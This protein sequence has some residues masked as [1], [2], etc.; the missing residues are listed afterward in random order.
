MLNLLYCIKLFCSRLL[1]PVVYTVWNLSFCAT[2]KCALHGRASAINDSSSCDRHKVSSTRCIIIFVLWFLSCDLS[3][4]V[5][6]HSLFGSRPIK[7]AMLYFTCLHVLLFA[8]WW[9]DK[10]PW[11]IRPFLLLNLLW[12]MLS[13]GLLVTIKVFIF[14]IVF[15]AMDLPNNGLSGNG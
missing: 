4:I 6:D 5:C 1:H 13:A 12:P 8:C 3:S 10:L 11:N 15:I 9:W 7:L 2:L 14:C